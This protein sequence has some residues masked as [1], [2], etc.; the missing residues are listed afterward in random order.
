MRKWI[1]GMAALTM[2]VAAACAPEETT[3]P[4][5]DG[6]TPT[7]DQTAADCLQEH[8]DD[9]YTT[10]A[11]STRNLTVGTDFD[12]MFPP[13]ILNRNPESGRG[14]ESAVTYEVADRLGFA[15]DDVKWVSVPFNKSYA[16]GPK[17]FDFDINNI[18]VTEERDQAVDFS[19]SYYDLTQALMTLKGS[20]IEDATT[21]DDIKDAVFGAQIGTTSLQFINTVIQPTTDPKVFDSTGDAKAALR[22][23]TVDGLVLDLPTA[24]FEANINTPNGV[25]VGQF[26][27]AGEY[28]GLLFEEGSPLVECVDL[29]IDEMTEDGTLER[30]QNKWLADYLAVP[31]IE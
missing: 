3:P 1:L 15:E 26:R 22:N 13:W 7:V 18:S 11:Y 12:Y 27:N 6:E 5:D 4:A 14:F 10:G 9:L 31:V 17:D 19:K 2:L 24:Y 8:R 30:L 25:L 28:L 20:P 29:A 16:P 23:G 21:M